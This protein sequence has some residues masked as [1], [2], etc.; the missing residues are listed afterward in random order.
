MAA[1]ANETGFADISDETSSATA[2]RKYSAHMRWAETYNEKSTKLAALLEKGYDSRME[3]RLE[4]NL[5]KGENSIAACS[6]V[7]QLLQQKQYAK[8]GENCGLYRTNQCKVG[9]IQ[10]QCS[11]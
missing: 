5:T 9:Q 10:C 7:A 2:L 11:C 4:D 8:V 6:Q 1:L 3:R